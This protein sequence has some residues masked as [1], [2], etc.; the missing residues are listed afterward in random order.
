MCCCLWPPAKAAACTIAALNLGTDAPEDNQFPQSST[1]R[2]TAQL[3]V[4]D[5]GK[6][7][8]VYAFGIV[9]WELLTWTLPFE[10]LNPWQVHK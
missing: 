4:Q 10:S 9:L 2:L 7:S 3:L 5:Y 8:D 6:A 1:P